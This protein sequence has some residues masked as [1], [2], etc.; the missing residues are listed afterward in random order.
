[1]QREIADTIDISGHEGH[2]LGFRRE[3]IFA[4]PFGTPFLSWS[5]FLASPWAVYPGGCKILSDQRL[6]KQDGIELH[7]QSDLESCGTDGPKLARY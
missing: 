7:T 2:N 1:M 5:I 3:F 4:L 6:G